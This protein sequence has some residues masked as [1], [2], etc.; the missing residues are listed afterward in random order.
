[1]KSAQVEDQR[2]IFSF[3]DGWSSSSLIVL[4]MVP[5][6]LPSVHRTLHPPT[7]A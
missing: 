6:Y 2:G 1:M 4:D 7:H 5:F 3:D